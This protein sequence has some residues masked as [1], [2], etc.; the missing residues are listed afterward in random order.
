MFKLWS[1]W[2]GCSNCSLFDGAEYFAVGSHDEIR[3]IF[4]C[5][6]C[7]FASRRHVAE[8]HI[9]G[10]G[11]WEWVPVGRLPNPHVRISKE[12]A[13]KQPEGWMPSKSDFPVCAQTSQS[14]PADAAAFDAWLAHLRTL[15]SPRSGQK[16]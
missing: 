7:G 2:F 4:M 14:R 3:E 1:R 13:T 10:C 6:R 15:G 8:E 16:E 5:C 12:E 9:P 11:P